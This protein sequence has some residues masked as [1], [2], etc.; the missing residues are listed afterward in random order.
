MLYPLVFDSI[1][2]QVENDGFLYKKVQ[3]LIGEMS[4]LQKKML[5]KTLKGS[6]PRH[7]GRTF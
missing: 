3:R 6:S 2:R 4:T 5:H 1:S 7:T